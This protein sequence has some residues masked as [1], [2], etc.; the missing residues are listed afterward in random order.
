MKKLLYVVVAYLGV[1]LLA[2]QDGKVERDNILANVEFYKNIGKRIPNETAVRWMEL[3]QSRTSSTGRLGT[4]NYSVTAENMQSV[5]SSVSSLTGV[6]FH[7]ALDE[8]GKHHFILIPVD[9]TLTVW[10]SI[11]GRKYFDANTD[12]EISQETARQWAANYETTHPGKVWF[13][14]FGRAIFD[15]ILSISFFQT[16]QIEPALSDLDLTPQLLLVITNG[17]TLL[18]GRTEMDDAAVYDVS[19][20]CPPCAVH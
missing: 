13:H 2:C 5:L 9:E 3:Y 19:S 4:S 14:Y 1:S 11:P 16:L 10:T 6:A 12:S 8:T 20:P 7:H 18:T 17:N 15:E